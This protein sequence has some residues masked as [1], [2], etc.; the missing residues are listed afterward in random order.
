MK[1]YNKTALTRNERFIKAIIYGTLATIII[2]IGYGLIFNFAKIPFM[3]SM[4]YIL[5][6]YAIGYVIQI[7]GKGVHLR[8]SI[9]AVILTLIAFLFGDLIRMFGLSIFA[10]PTNLFLSIKLWLLRIDMIELI[11]KG[12][13]LYYAYINAR[14]A[15]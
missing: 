7:K 10:N 3:F 12:L 4:T 13:G 8:F 9:L 5:I 14:I 11:F 15:S 2:A 1:V 6:G